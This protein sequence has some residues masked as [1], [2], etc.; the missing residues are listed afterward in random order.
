MISLVILLKSI[1][2]IKVIKDQISIAKVIFQSNNTHVFFPMELKALLVIVQL[3]ETD[4]AYSI[5][6]SGPPKLTSKYQFLEVN[7]R[8]HTLY[9]CQTIYARHIFVV[10]F[11]LC[12]FFL[13]GWWCWLW[14]G[15]GHHPIHDFS[16]VTA[17]SYGSLT[18]NYLT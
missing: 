5:H 18:I 1:V 13:F 2:L 9:S 14:F 10:S 11:I 15:C 17:T 16:L 3:T 4:F 7:R 12:W 6:G 8:M